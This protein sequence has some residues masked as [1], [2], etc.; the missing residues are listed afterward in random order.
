MI[1]SLCNELPVQD[2]RAGLENTDRR[3]RNCPLKAVH[4]DHEIAPQ[5][6]ESWQRLSGEDDV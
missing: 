4:G 6:T 2:W 5:E 3:T 1:Q